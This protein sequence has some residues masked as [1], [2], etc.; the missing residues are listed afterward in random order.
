MIHTEMTYYLDCEFDGHGG[1]LISIA[2]VPEVGLGLYLVCKTEAKDKWV[3][4]NV[5]PHLT[6]YRPDFIASTNKVGDCLRN[7]IG[8]INSFKVV[9]DSAV[10]IMRFCNAFCTGTDNDYFS[11]YYEH[12]V[13]EVHNVRTYP[14]D[15][16]GAIQHNAWWD[17]MA[18]RHALKQTEE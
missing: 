11:N 9:A 6:A 3:Q 14:T 2:L 4:R 16:E 17:A 1:P 18:L 8:D 7:Y 13:F 10:D 5:I 12:I 15:L